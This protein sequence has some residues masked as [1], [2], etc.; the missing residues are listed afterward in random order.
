MFLLILLAT[1]SACAGVASNQAKVSGGTAGTPPVN[2]L[3][4]LDTREI[5][6]L[7]FKYKAPTFRQT[8]KVTEG[9]FQIPYARISRFVYG[10]TRHLRVGQTIA[11]T[12]LAGAG[13]LLLLLSKSHTHYLTLYYTDDTNH[14][15]VIIFEVGKEAIG[16]LID[17]LEVRTGRKLELDNGPIA[18]A[19]KK[20]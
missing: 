4:F 13:G 10:E 5:G 11:L 20:P 7:V 19:K 1:Q 8:R 17:S 15:Q 3:G 9:S 2:S 6:S 18:P 16:P 14:Q 12:A